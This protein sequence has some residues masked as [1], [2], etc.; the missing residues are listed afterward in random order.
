MYIFNK[1]LLFVSH[2]N[3]RIHWTDLYDWSVS[4]RCLHFDWCHSRAFHCERYFKTN[5]N[6]CE[7]KMNMWMDEDLLLRL[8]KAG[9]SQDFIYY[10]HNGQCWLKWSNV[11]ITIWSFF[12][13]NP[14]AQITYTNFW[15]AD[16]YTIHCLN[17]L[18]KLATEIFYSDN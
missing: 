18:L 1:P 15:D 14:A 5:M 17:I 8:S 7:N 16:Y 6:G 11:N 2:W 12:I 3:L 4:K 10:N 9:Y 13:T